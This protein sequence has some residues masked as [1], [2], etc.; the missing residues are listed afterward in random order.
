MIRVVTSLHAAMDQEDETKAARRLY[1][2]GRIMRQCER[3]DTAFT[4]SSCFP[5]DTRLM[6]TFRSLLDVTH[7]MQVCA[8]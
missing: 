5:L 6:M 1:T 4:Q 2:V 7:S 8:T 3:T